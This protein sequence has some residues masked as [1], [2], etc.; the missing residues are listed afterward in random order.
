LNEKPASPQQQEIKI[1]LPDNL[2]GGAYCNYMVVQH[3]KEEFVMDF[4]LI[5]PPIGT[6]TARVIMSPGHMKRTITA[7]QA[8]MKNYESQ[9]GT[10]VEA[11]EPTKG[12]IGFPTI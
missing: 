8:N 6:V 11:Q 1:Q 3:T 4:V 7:L 5:T 2:K 10:L 9:F 12:K